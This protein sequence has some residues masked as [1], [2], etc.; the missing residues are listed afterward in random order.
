MANLLA[1]RIKNVQLTK[2]QQKIAD[3]FIK[4]QDKLGNLSSIEVADK[5]GVSDA[6]IIRFSRAIGFDGYADLKAHIYDMLVENSSNAMSLTDRMN[7]N[8]AKFSGHNTTEEFASIMQKN[9]NNVFA[10]NNLEDFSK[11]ADM[12]IK[13]KSRYVIGLRGCKGVATSFGRLLA[14]MM[15]GVEVLKDNEC[16]SISSAQNMSSKD[17]AVMFVFSR[18]YKIDKHYLDLAR[19]RKAKV[20]MI[21]DD[22]T[23]PFAGYADLTLIAP[24]ESMNFFRSTLGVDVIAEYLLTLIGRRIDPRKR[25]DERD[26]L[27]ADQRL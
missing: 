9:M 7:A 18:F 6:S 1:D 13:A 17:V 23:G 24:V 27:T 3:Y 14:F 2:K 5:I 19:D 21:V 11:A 12:I 15:P 4:N 10:Y 26:A 16:T 20:I 22:V 8:D 25:I